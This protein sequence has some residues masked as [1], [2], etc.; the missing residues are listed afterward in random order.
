MPSLSMA[1]GIDASYEVA[2]GQTTVQIR[3]NSRLN[4]RAVYSGTGQMLFHWVQEGKTQVWRCDLSM[5][6]QRQVEVKETTGQDGS[7]VLEVG[8]EPMY[9]AGL[10]LKGRFVGALISPALHV[11]V[12]WG[13]DVWVFVIRS[14]WFPLNLQFDRASLSVKHNMSEVSATISTMAGGSATGQVVIG[15]TDFKNASLAVKRTLGFNS[16]EEQVCEAVPGTQPFSWNP[17]IRAFDLTLVV[18]E[19]LTESHLVE[20]AKGLGA[21]ESSGFFGPGGVEG[22]FIL[23]DGP[24]ISYSWILRGHRGLL[25]NPEDQTGAKFTW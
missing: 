2:A 18:K 5:L 8:L 22:D 12:P 9:P 25:E 15:G 20:I 3:S 4:I 17:I 13:S 23:C 24:A 14:P 11:D 21:Q 19:T 1:E 6:E 16:S 10:M 7:Q